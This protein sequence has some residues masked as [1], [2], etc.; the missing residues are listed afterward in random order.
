MHILMM[1]PPGSGKGTQGKIVAE[2][3]KTPH[4]STGD[5]FRQAM[6]VTTP[7][8]E[9][10]KALINKGQLV[11]DSLTNAMVFDRLE[12]PDCKDGYI[13]DG[14]PRTL[15]Q[16]EALDAYLAGKGEALDFVVMLDVSEETIL[17]RILNRRFCKDCG[18]S[19]NITTNPPKVENIC[20]Y[21]G[22]PLFA[23]E[24]DT[25]KTVL[26]RIDVY[27]M[28]TKPL[29]EFYEKKGIVCYIS[30]DD[31]VKEATAEIGKCL[32]RDI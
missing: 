18:G 16:A 32:G 30:G 22:K 15:P 1:G 5:I 7:Q 12:Q 11:P 10:L 26:D 19:F 13:L 29:I 21:C 28:Q 27:E 25:E 8:S 17:D 4:I 3:L 20:D 14:Y 24:D 31:S 2:A 9:T 23:R 6:S